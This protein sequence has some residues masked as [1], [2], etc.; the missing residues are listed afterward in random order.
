[1]KRRW[2]QYVATAMAGIF[3]ISSLVAC[4]SKGNALGE[5]NQEEQKM[6]RYVEKDMEL[7]K[8]IAT[9]NG[10]GTMG[11]YT[12]V[13]GTKKL[14]YQSSENWLDVQSYKIDGEQ[15]VKEEIAWKLPS[16][17]E[18]IENIQIGGDGKLYLCL[19]NIHT[20]KTSFY[21]VKE[22]ELIEYPVEHLKEKETYD[23]GMAFYP[24]VDD[25]EMMPDESLVELEYGKGSWISKDGMVKNE[26]QGAYGNGCLARVNDKIAIISQDQESVIRIY[27]EGKK[28][29]VQILEFP[30][31]EL[32]IL[33]GTED[34]KILAVNQSGFHILQK[35][36]SKWETIFESNGMSMGLPSYNVINLMEGESDDYYILYLNDKTYELKH[37]VYDETVVLEPS[38]TL[39]IYSLEQWD[40]IQQAVVLF[41]K[42]HP[43]VKVDYRVAL[44]N[45]SITISDAVKALNTELLSGKGADILITESLP[46]DS[47]I[48][49]GILL[50]L[51]DII[52]PM[53]EQGSLNKNVIEACKMDGKLYQVPQ[54]F[55]PF[56]FSG[57]KETLSHTGSLKELADYTKTLKDPLF[58]TID[59]SRLFWDLYHIYGEEMYEE[60]GKVTEESI[61]QFLTSIKA[62]SE[63]SNMIEE[64]DSKD[65]YQSYPM[66]ATFHDVRQLGIEYISDEW[67][68]MMATHL[69]KD[70]KV[71]VQTANG[72]FIP[73][74]AMGINASSK[75]IE[76][77]KEFMKV[78]LSEKVQ[79]L[80]LSEGYPVNE[81]AMDVLYERNEKNFLASSIH[82]TKG[83]IHFEWPD[84]KE[85][86]Q[87]LDL[88]RSAN[89]MEMTEVEEIAE[90]L[91]AEVKKY[92][93][94]EQDLD[95]TVQKMIGIYQ[96]KDA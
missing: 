9:E 78:A 6:G 67:G 64:F 25:W 23:D 11:I 28:D 47:Y 72:V 22:G 86:S 42:E 62:I 73:S 44:K 10:V 38:K 30:N 94:E 29:A 27:E 21:Q 81:K 19:S 82:V 20:M 39:T 74:N 52:E 36:G 3:M 63:Q 31:D 46:I 37:Y 26:L 48:E 65:P 68:L 15:V 95:S 33:Q 35:G 16:E 57:S 4:S 61:K 5:E 40:G 77:A 83:T 87:F 90:K 18:M 79:K 91:L 56:F 12:D 8:Q 88:V 69:M 51:S 89:K 41:E 75:N 49:K 71:E 84:K 85:Q 59:Y 58:G 17:E 32:P 92:L 45:D 76:L 43:D 34:G 7:P 1:M 13:D 14:Y 96:M 53:V 2:K 80:N 55:I 66:I 60:D 70:G 24:T 54:W 93:K 50:E